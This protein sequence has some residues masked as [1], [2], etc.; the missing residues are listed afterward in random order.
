MNSAGDVPETKEFAFE[1][2]AVLRKWAEANPKLVEGYSRAMDKSIKFML[3]N[4]EDAV[5]ILKDNYFQ[6][7]DID[8]V[9]ISLKALLPSI[10]PE[11]KLSETAIKN[12][13]TVLKDLG[14]MKDL[15]NTSEGKLWTN[16]WNPDMKK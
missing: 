7:T 4:T 1:S 10:N 8:T 3:D 12:Q 5:K 2:I 13:L 14:V 9:R 6:D 11:G 16:K 15:P